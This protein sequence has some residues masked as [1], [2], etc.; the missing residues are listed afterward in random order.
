MK[1]RGTQ[2]TE[3]RFGYRYNNP[4]NI[5]MYR[6]FKIRPKYKNE[7]DIN[8]AEKYFLPP[9]VRWAESLEWHHDVY[10]SPFYYLASTAIF[11]LGVFWSSLLEAAKNLD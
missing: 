6:I 3:Y 4:W 9:G 2:K 11:G 10:Y 1:Y 8:N 7:D 5:L